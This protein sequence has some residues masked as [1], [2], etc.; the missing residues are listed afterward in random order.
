MTTERL[1]VEAVLDILS[2]KGALAVSIQGFEPRPAQAAMMR[3]VIDA[4]HHDQISLIEAGTGTGKSFA[5]LIPALLWAKETKERTLISTNT[6][7]LQE[8]LLK[9]DFPVVANA[10]KLDIKAVIVKGMNNYLCLRKLSE[11]LEERYFLTPEENDEIQKI[12]AWSQGTAEDGSRSSVPFQTSHKVWDKVAAESDA[13]NR[14]G[15]PHY[16]KCHFFKA[17][18]GAHDAQILISNHHLLFADLTRRMESG[19][20]KDPSILPP[21]QRIILDEAHHIEDIATEHFAARASYLDIVRLTARISSEKQGKEY[22]KLSFIKDRLSSY[23]RHEAGQ[24]IRSILQRLTIDIPGLRRDVL[25]KAHDTFTSYQNFCMLLL[26]TDVDGTSDQLNQEGKVRILSRHHTFHKWQ[27]ELLPLSK[28]LT[29]SIERY[30]SALT[31]LFEDLKRIEEPHIEE[32]IKTASYEVNSFAIRLNEM[33]NIIER[34]A[35][36]TAPSD[37]VRWIELNKL[38]SILNTSLVDA[39][40]RVSSL[41]ADHVFKR[42]STV[43]LCSATLTTNNQFSFIR[44]RLGLTEEYFKERIITENAYESPFDFKSQALLAI[45]TD[46][47]APNDSAFILKAAEII[48]Q[49]L[50]SSRGHAFILFTSYAMLTE[51]Y[52]L[53]KKRMEEHRMNGLKQGD[54]DRQ[55]LLV[56]FKAIDH[57]VLFGTDSFWEGVDVVGD[58]LRCV[59]IVKLPFRVPS[60]PLIQARSEAILAE[61]K[62]PFM[63]YSLP[64]AIVK[65]KQGFGRLIRN[66]KDRGLVLCLDHRILSKPYGQQFLSSLP[67]CQRAFASSIALQPKIHDFYRRK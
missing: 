18:R 51:C 39:E 42:F 24:P 67:D 57:S 28:Q 58:A 9:K 31:G 10:L 20:Y 1:N 6:I 55:A 32:Q 17:R 4:Y 54:E 7:P 11:A 65:F 62:D 63:E 14:N 52:A 33:C 45:P 8:Q 47:P 3:N 27:N 40:L 48:W 19:N 38:K 12:D 23:F 64:Q 41:L 60:E 16:Q 15:C 29:A 36:S 34:F 50:L 13:C 61:G 43:I 2:P 66:R 46:L 37:K 30:T 22:G 49:T 5:Y 59:I 21:Y 44:S 26:K 53:L 35:G 56:K 25:N